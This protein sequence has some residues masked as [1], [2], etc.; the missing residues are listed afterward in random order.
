MTD[1]INNEYNKSVSDEKNINYCKNDTN[2]VD[3]INS[4]EEQKSNIEE[5]QMVIITEASERQLCSKQ[6]FAVVLTI[7][8]EEGI[9]KEEGDQPIDIVSCFDGHGPDIAIDIIRGLDLKHHFAKVSPAESIQ[10]TIDEEI[11]RKKKRFHL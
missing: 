1:F 3:Q 8:S 9:E 11:E 4:Y 5:N 7:E 6:D 2:D 10:K